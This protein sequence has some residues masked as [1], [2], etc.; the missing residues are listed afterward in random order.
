MGGKTNSLPPA[1]NVKVRDQLLA[2][3]RVH[4]G[5][6][7]AHARLDRVPRRLLLRRALVEV[8]E[9]RV[10]RLVDLLPIRLAVL[11]VVAEPLLLLLRVGR[12]SPVLGD[13]ADELRGDPGRGAGKVEEGLDDCGAFVRLLRGGLV[14][15]DLWGEN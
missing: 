9:P 12:A 13:L 6:L 15:L 10:Q 1:A 3:L 11:R 5:Q 8:G 14:C 2:Q 4:L 7:L